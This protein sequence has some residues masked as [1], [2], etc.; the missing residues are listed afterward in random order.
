MKFE[1]TDLDEAEPGYL[2]GTV[3][4]FGTLHHA[5]FIRVV[6]NE[7]DEQVAWIPPDG[8]NENES[9]LE[10]LQR[11]YPAYLATVQLPE[12]DGEWLCVI[13]PYGR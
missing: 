10:D 12:R 5:E 1:I 13:F 9:R 8:E 11:Y 7:K 4:M 6:E 3:D 2:L